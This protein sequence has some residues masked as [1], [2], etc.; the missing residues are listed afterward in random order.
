M[1]SVAVLASYPTAPR[2]P[3]VMLTSSAVVLDGAVLR[4]LLGRDVMREL[5]KA[6]GTVLDMRSR[7]RR[8]SFT[9]GHTLAVRENNRME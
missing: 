8:N 4:E 3:D 6:A 1:P 7:M 2:A 9:D 5:D